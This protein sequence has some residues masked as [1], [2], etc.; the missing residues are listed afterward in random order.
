MT[1]RLLAA[2][3]AC[4]LVGLLAVAPAQVDSQLR[5]E[6]ER[7]ASEY[8]TLLEERQ[9][10]IARIEEA[11]GD[12]RGELEARIA[13]RD[14]V[15]ARIA[16]LAAEER[17][18]EARIAELEAERADTQ[19]RI[20]TEQEDLARLEG[21]I[22]TLLV[23]L[24]RQR[25]G[26]SVTAL[27]GA[28]SLHDVRVKNRYLS[29]L[30]QQHVALVQEV[31]ARLSSLRD[32]R[33]DLEQQLAEL[34]ASREEL[35]ATR[36]AQ[37]DARAELESIIAQLN[38]S[39]E[40]QQAQRAELMA[41]QQRLEAELARTEERL[42]AEIQRLRE[43]EA[44]LREE[45]EAFVNDRQQREALE[46][47]ADRTAERIRALTSPQEPNPSGFVGPLDGGTLVSEY[48]DGNN[49]FV[50]IRAEEEGAPVYVVQGGVVTAAQ[51]I[52]ANDGFMVAVRHDE[53]LT[54][55]YTNLTDPEVQVGDRLQRGQVIGYL[56]GGTLPPPDVLRLY[57]RLSDGTREAFVDPL[58]LLGL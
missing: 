35:A 54:T 2:S 51:S 27:A 50:A 18:L 5:E 7:Q 24:H 29:I 12:T 25:Q 41:A 37:E 9:A 16:E 43:E 17:A 36:S 55:V 3:L 57:A 58:P 47:E 34:S 10:E 42:Q 48:G 38:Q 56:G 53:A 4:L 45:A 40:G 1:A 23:S 39:E 33:A 8:Q 13:E 20:E 52:G 21:R 14:R 31:N 6:L 32:L 46:A 15:S 11:L 19:A 49:S 26:R 22:Q 28:D 30:S 44:R